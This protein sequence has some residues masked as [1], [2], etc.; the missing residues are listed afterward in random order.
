[1]MEISCQAVIEDVSLKQQSA[2]LFVDH[3]LVLVQNLECQWALLAALAGIKDLFSKHP[4]E[5]KVHK[6][7]IIEK[8]RER[9]CDND[10]MVRAKLFHLLKIVVFPGLKEVLHE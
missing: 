3:G 1:M 5:L 7:A 4:S 9:I 2:L 8:L 6:V 10:K